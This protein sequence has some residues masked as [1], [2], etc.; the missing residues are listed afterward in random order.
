MTASTTTWDEPRNAREEVPVIGT[1]LRCTTGRHTDRVDQM[2]RHL[3]RLL[4]CVALLATALPGTTWA[5]DDPFEAVNRRIH[6]FNIAVRAKMLGPLAE[7]YL[8]ATAPETRRGIANVLSNLREPV[9]AV[10]GLVAGDLDLATSAAARFGIN[11]TLGLGG[12]RDPATEIGFPRR[13]FGI[14]DAACS[15]GV[16]SG[17]FLVLPLLGP[18]TFRD[19][20]ALAAQSAALSDVLGADIYLAWSGSDLF[21]GYAQFHRE[22]E[23]VQSESLDAYAVYRSAYLQQRATVCPVDRAAAAGEED[24]GP[25][26]P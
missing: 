24:S 20:G 4:A 21:V 23:R 25:E 5:A 3:C 13:N 1:G 15:W 19:A 2:P 14:A 26:M 9:T 7:L 16:P 11:S 12:L 22:L 6:G 10:S 18:S 17:P 8:S